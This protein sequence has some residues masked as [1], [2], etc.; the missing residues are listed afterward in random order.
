MCTP[1]NVSRGSTLDLL[2][3][4]DDGCLEVLDCVGKVES[5]RPKSRLLSS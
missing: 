5:N 1:N 3:E 4:V 2:D